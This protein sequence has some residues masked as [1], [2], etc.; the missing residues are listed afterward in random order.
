MPVTV[1][2]GTVSLNRPIRSVLFT[3]EHFSESPIN[4]SFLCQTLLTDLN[5]SYAINDLL[6]LFLSQAPPSMFNICSIH[7]KIL[8]ET[9]TDVNNKVGHYGR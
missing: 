8:S 4:N 3:A 9:H 2:G 7:T 6:E 1:N 5:F